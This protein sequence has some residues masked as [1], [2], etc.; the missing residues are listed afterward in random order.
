MKANCVACVAF[1]CVL[2]VMLPGIWVMALSSFPLL[3]FN[4]PYA[5]AAWT[6]LMTMGEVKGLIVAETATCQS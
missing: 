6:A 2:Q 5:V 4:S 1:V 3:F